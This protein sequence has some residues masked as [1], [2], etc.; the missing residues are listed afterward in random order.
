[1]RN[2]PKSLFDPSL[3]PSLMLSPISMV[4]TR[5]SCGRCVVYPVVRRVEL[6]MLGAPF[7]LAHVMKGAESTVPV[8]VLTRARTMGVDY[9]T[10]KVGGVLDEAAVGPL[11]FSFWRISASW[12]WISRRKRPLVF[13]V[14][15]VHG[16]T[17]GCKGC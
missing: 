1:M 9:L 13:G 15:F 3:D 17:V 16:V 5:C 8:E 4:L 14:A 11:N 7:A 6:L 10:H 12:R 2:S